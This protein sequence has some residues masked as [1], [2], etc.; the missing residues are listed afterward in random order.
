MNS[1]I[2]RR[3]SK[4]YNASESRAMLNELIASHSGDNLAAALVYNEFATAAQAAR[5]AK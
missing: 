1:M 5:F 3:A 2:T 4:G